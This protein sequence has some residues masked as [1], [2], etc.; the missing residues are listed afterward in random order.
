[1]ECGELLYDRSVPLRL[2]EVVNKIY[3]GQQY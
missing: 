2:K 3:V 1:M